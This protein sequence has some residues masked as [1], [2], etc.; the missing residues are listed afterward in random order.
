MNARR[1]ASSLGA[2]LL[3]AF[4]A[5]NPAD[6]QT[7]AQLTLPTSAPSTAAPG[8]QQQGQYL[9]AGVYLDGSQLFR[10]AD[11]VK[12]SGGPSIENR[13]ASIES[14]IEQV[15]ATTGSGNRQRT[16]FDPK[17]TKIE[18][19]NES[20]V[21]VL[22]AVDA[23]HPVPFPIVTV[24][25]VDAKFYGLTITQLATAWQTVLQSAITHALV[26]RQPEVERQSAGLVVRV[27]I[28]LVA[29]TFAVFAVL[30]FITRRIGALTEESA[31]AGSAVAEEEAKAVADT[32]GETNFRRRAF[33]LAVRGMKPRRRLRLYRAAFEILVWATLLA[34]FIAVS[35]AFSLFPQTTPLAR[36]I[37]RIAFRV[38]TTILVAGLA[39]R[40]IDVAIT[41]GAGVWEV[42]GLMP[43]EDRARRL[44]RIPTIAR[45]ISGGRRTGELGRHDRRFGSDCALARGAKLRA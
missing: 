2:A 20:S 4:A 28:G 35:W 36:H 21:T 30:A 45:T 44:L 43:A 8:I 15:V 10:I 5:P 7:L 17:T 22:Q 13:R 6:A 18:L 19:R 29:A 16:V 33:A 9:T 32:E 24:T 1:F 27:A 34:W 40:L 3:I 12:P 31:A 38:V 25:S 26:I 14:S 42:G 41:R 23:S 11:L 37:V 39:N